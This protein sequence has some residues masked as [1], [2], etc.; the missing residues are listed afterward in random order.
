M[1]LLTIIIATAIILGIVFL[2]RGFTSWGGRWGATPENAAA[3]RR[4]AERP[5]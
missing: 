5:S 1:N 4:P 3:D 2:F